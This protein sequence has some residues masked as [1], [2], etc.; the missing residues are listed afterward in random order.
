VQAICNAEDE[1]DIQ[2]AVV[3]LAEQSAELAEFDENIPWDEKEVDQKNR[4]ELLC[5]QVEEEISSIERKLKPVE[6]LAVRYLEETDE[7][8]SSDALKM[9]NV[10]IQ[11][12]FFS[13]R[14]LAV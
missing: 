14:W 10:R 12:L 8:F 13:T 6:R 7:Q 5:S 1:Q 11:T 9:A 4:D 2:A 3:A